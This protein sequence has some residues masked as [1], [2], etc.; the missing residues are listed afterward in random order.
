MLGREVARVVE[1]HA[2]AV[3]GAE[4]RESDVADAHAS[5]VVEEQLRRRE[6]AEHEAVLVHV[7][8]RAR[9]VAPETSAV[10]DAETS[11][12]S[13]HVLEGAAPQVLADHEDRAGL[14]APVKDTREVRVAQRRGAD[15]AVAE[16]AA[17]VLVRGEV[18]RAAP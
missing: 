10:V 1:R 13:E 9:D 7:G 15:D 8:E 6:V 16:R 17:H 14:L 3:R 5:L 4:S 11:S 18:A 2:F 12:R